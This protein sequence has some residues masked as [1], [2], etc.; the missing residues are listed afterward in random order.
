MRID[1]VTITGADDGV[2]PQDLIKLHEEFPFVEFGILFSK[3]RQGTSRYPSYDWITKLCDNPEFKAPLSGHLCGEYVKEVLIDGRHSWL[4][5]KKNY[6]TSF[7]RIQLNM[8]NAMFDSFD[9]AQLVETILNSPGFFHV[10]L[11]SHRGFLRLDEIEAANHTLI[12]F[13]APGVDIIYDSSGGRGIPIT[14]YPVASTHAFSGY[15]GYAGGIT[16]DNI[17]GVITD[18]HQVCKKRSSI[19]IDMESGVREDDKFSVTKAR[20][21]LL[22]AKERLNA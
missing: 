18:L 8:S 9:M 5:F 15:C 17:A 4:F 14:E 6:Y 2:D 21:C 7:N 16:P 10:I 11:Q 13:S 22:V 19:W 12:G 3:E 1:R 20:E